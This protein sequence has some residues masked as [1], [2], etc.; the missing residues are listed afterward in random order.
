MATF[1]ALSVLSR[2]PPLLFLTISIFYHNNA[3]LTSALFFPHVPSTSFAGS[4][5]PRPGPHPMP[6]SVR[7]FLSLALLSG[8]VTFPIATNLC[9]PALPTSS[10]P[11]RRH[12]VVEHL[13]R[14]QGCLFPTLTPYMVAEPLVMPAAFLLLFSALPFTAEHSAPYGYANSLCIIVSY[15]SDAHVTAGCLHR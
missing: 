6:G 13:A 2:N 8:G 7:V 9:L 1:S 10:A 14:E 5:L 15:P 3:G 11:A 4:L 12:P